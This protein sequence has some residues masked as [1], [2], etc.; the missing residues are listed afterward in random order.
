MSKFLHQMEDSQKYTETENAQICTRNPIERCF[1]NWKRR[2]PVPAFGIRLKTHKVEAIV[3]A[4]AILHN[5]AC[6]LNDELPPIDPDV[7]EAINFVNNVEV[8]PG[9]DVA[10][11]NNNRRLQ[12]IEYFNTLVR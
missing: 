6:M 4:T 11:R 5:I 10:G 7:E 2:F 12:F 9:R 3:V 8:P 1:G